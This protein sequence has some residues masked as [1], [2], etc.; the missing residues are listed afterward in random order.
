MWVDPNYPDTLWVSGDAFGVFA[1]STDGGANW[2]S[3][4]PGVFEQTY[5]FPPNTSTPLNPRLANFNLN[6][7][8]LNAG[9]TALSYGKIGKTTN[10][11][12]SW[13]T[14]GYEPQST[15]FYDVGYNTS[16]YFTGGNYG[17][18]HRFSGSDDQEHVNYL[19]CSDDHPFDVRA[20]GAVSEDLA[21][22]IGGFS[23]TTAQAPFRQRYQPCIFSQG[24]ATVT[25]G[26]TY[27]IITLNWSAT[28]RQNIYKWY[29]AKNLHS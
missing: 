21:H 12:A 16:D 9:Y 14:V 6:F 8:N 10:G 19:H 15:W 18:I 11:G 25:T 27:Y 26:D 29:V 28:N 20:I 2:T 5:T 7:Q 22:A 24:N 23:G 13:D 4:Q 3:Y 17:V 1:K